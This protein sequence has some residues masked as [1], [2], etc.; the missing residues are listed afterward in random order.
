MIRNETSLVCLRQDGN[1]KLLQNETYG[2]IGLA[3][4]DFI[5]VQTKKITS[6]TYFDQLIYESRVYRPR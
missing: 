6:E 3:L 1:I 5:D 2:D 4:G